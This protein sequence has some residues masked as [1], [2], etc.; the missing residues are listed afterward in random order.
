MIEFPDYLGE[1]FV[2]AQAART[3]DPFL[4]RSL[5]CVRV[6]TTGSSRRSSMATETPLR[7][8]A[9]C[10]LERYALA[11]ADRLIW[12]GGD[13]SAPIAG[14]TGPGGWRP[15]YGSATRISGRRWTRSADRDFEL[16]P[17]E[18]LRLLYVGRLERRKG[19]ED[20]VGPS[21]V[22]SRTM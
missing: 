18:P 11:H 19:I 16:G 10:E 14:T 9:T 7:R 4:A 13:V 15:A 3:L 2:T 1:G 17:D 6:H 20:L 8:R 5:V 21:R 12:Q 22:A